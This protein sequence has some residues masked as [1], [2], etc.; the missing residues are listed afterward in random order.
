MKLY[1]EDEMIKGWFIGNFNPS[2]LNIDTC[3]VGV[4]RYKAGNSEAP[5]VHKIATEITMVVEG[6]VEMN[7]VVYGKGCIVVLDPGEA[8]SFLALEDTIT[9]VVKSP[10]VPGDKYN[11][12]DLNK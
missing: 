2:V 6:K 4:K 9:V 10:C 3:E 12:E 11:S 7:N 8:T 5:H 1:H